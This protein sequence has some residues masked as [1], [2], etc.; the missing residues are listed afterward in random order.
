MDHHCPWVNNCVGHFNYGHFI[1]FLFFVDIACLYH[2]AMV[3]ARVR[4]AMVNG[5]WVEPSTSELI[6]IVLN[7]VACV[8]VIVMVGL[9]SLYHYYC[10]LLNT[11]T[12]EGW[13]KNKVATLVRR[14]KIEEIK[15]PYTLGVFTNIGAV[16]GDNPLLWC[17]PSKMRGDGLRFP[18]SGGD[19]PDNISQSWPPQDPYAREHEEAISQSLSERLNTSSPFTYGDGQFNPELIPSNRTSRL[20]RRG[21]GSRVPPYHPSYRQPEEPESEP[22]ELESDIDSGESDSMAEAGLGPRVRRGSE[23]LEVKTIDREEI[24][25]RY[26]STRGEEALR[27]RED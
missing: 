14:G 16:L 15:F 3:T 22:S 21:V 9:F 1:R 8:P 17:W 25:R 19:D 24:L 11:T 26:I 6:F 23:G 4:G 10:L 2:L 5:Y 20:K 18:V 27:S 13:E 7:Y 12:I